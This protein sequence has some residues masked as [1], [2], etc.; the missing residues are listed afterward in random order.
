MSDV[1]FEGIGPN[2]GHMDLGNRFLTTDVRNQAVIPIS[3]YHTPG[4]RPMDLISD[5]RVCG[6]RPNVG[7]LE[8]RLCINLENQM[9]KMTTFKMATGFITFA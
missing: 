8:F 2:I 6:I 9:E 1:E 4:S 3:Q 7:G 5:V